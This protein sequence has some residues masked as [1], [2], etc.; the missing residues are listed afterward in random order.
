VE[1]IAILNPCC[2]SKRAVAKPIPCGLPA[3]VM[4]ATFPEEFIYL[5]FT[6]LD[7][8]NSSGTAS[9]CILISGTFLPTDAILKDCSSTVVP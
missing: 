5:D 6:G 3:P 4:S 8:T 9:K 7:S 2:A 1:V